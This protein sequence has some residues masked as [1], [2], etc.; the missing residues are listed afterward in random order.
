VTGVAT[1][2]DLLQGGDISVIEGLDGWLF[3][4]EF[5][6]GDVMR[7]YTDADALD[8]SVYERWAAVLTRRR[9]NFARAGI[10]YLTLVV[11]DACLAYSDKLPDDIVLTRHSPFARLAALLDEETLQQCVYPLKALI[12]GRWTEETFQAVDS[13][14]TD[15]G[16]WLG[17]VETLR[18][19]LP[20]V[21]RLRMLGLD[22]IQW[23]SRPVFGSLGAVMNP[24]R[25]VILPAATVK[26]PRAQVTRR[27][28]TEIRRSYTVIEQDAPDLPV[29]VIVRD[30][31]MTAPAKFFAESFR[32]TIFVSSPNI[33]FHDLVER[34]RPD[35]I[36]HE[37]AE[38]GLVI[39]P[40]EPSRADFRWM[41]GDLLFDD[42]LAVADQRKSR[43]LLKAGRFEDAL[44][45]SDDVL[46]RVT[47]NARLMVHR[48]RL[49]ISLGR[50]DA[51][52]EAL[53]HATTLDVAD[54]SPWFFLAQALLQ[55]QRVGEAVSAFE[56][57]TE[58]EPGQEAFWP[59]AITSALHAGDPARALALSDRGAALHPDSPAL[60][61]ARSCVLVALDRVEEAEAAIRRSLTFEPGSAVYGQH[62]VSVL[63]RRGEWQAAYRHL[64]DLQRRTPGD[65]TLAQFA[66]YLDQ[67]SD[68][69]TAGH[70]AVHPDGDPAG[71]GEK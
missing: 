28:T 66:A 4:K 41:F 27:V 31:F 45:A 14:W 40:D 16:S 26:N 9:R 67:H 38:R 2:A 12:D 20:T 47:P 25:S 21:P 18:A 51:A 60:A 5:A 39:V 7:L 63:I 42:S 34:E 35:V 50:L 61:H 55:K 57:A 6:G 33:V 19:L 69:A 36:I 22:D 65:P 56:R 49:H 44:A 54:G 53:R 48:A 58:I 70:P 1:E 15:W 62:L 64:A 68:A 11:P 71:E 30:S 3:L 8:P 10:A 37:L 29:A 13:H 32:R 46:A 17:Y 59:T 24:E 43:S 52:I 23:T